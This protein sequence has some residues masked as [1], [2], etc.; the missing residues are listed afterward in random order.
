MAIISTLTSNRGSGSS[1]LTFYNHSSGSDGYDTF[2]GN[3]L[4]APGTQGSLYTLRPTDGAKLTLDSRPLP[5]EG[6]TYDLRLFAKNESGSPLGFNNNLEM[7]I[8]EIGGD[9]FDYNYHLQM[10][11]DTNGNGSYFDA[12]DLA[13]DQIFTPAQLRDGAQTQAWTQAIPA[14]FNGEYGMGT[15][16]VTQVPEPSGGLTALILAGSMAFALGSR[17]AWN[18]VAGRENRAK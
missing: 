14:G 16:G 7:A 10:L 12:T 2:D 17:R 6:D 15:L 13:I 1:D 4:E 9:T 3:W 5:Q 18:Y 8:N 11:V